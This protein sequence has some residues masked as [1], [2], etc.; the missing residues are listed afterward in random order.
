MKIEKNWLDEQLKKTIYRDLFYRFFLWTLFPLIIMCIHMYSEEYS[1]MAYINKAYASIIP[2]LNFIF[3]VSTLLV[4]AALYTK[5]LEGLGKI[6]SDKM[7]NTFHICRRFTSDVL[8]WIGG[9][10]TGLTMITIVNFPLVFYNDTN[11]LTLKNTYLAFYILFI[12]TTTIYYCIASFIII[13]RNKP[14][15]FSIPKLNKGWVVT[16]VYV[17]ILISWYSYIY[18]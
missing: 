15:T 9:I 6:S 17:I 2:T 12:L 4:I 18:S 11:E 8:I 14:L 5:H 7:I 10:V 1:A 16:M 13:R 3:P